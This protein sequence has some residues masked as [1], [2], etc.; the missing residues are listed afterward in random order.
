MTADSIL[1]T[2][3][4][5]A[6]REDV[7]LNAVEILTA[8]ETQIF[9]MLGKVEAIS[10]IHNYLTDTLRTP[11]VNAL[12]VEEAADY[13][14]SANTTP[15]RLTNLVE[16]CALN[17][18]VSRT[19]QQVAHYT[20]QNEL[21][22]QTQKALMDWANQAEFDLVRSAMASGVSGTA[23]QLMGI[24]VAISL[25]TNHTSQTSGTVWSA[26]ILDGLVMANWSNSNGDVATDIFM[27][28]VLRKNTDYFT[29]KSNVVVNAPGIST[30]VR[31]VSTYQT[32]FTTLNIHTHRYVQQSGD[33]TG[34]VLA[35]RPE[36]LKIAFLQNGGKPYIDTE[37]SRKGDYDN[38]AVVG[39]FTLEVH[40]QNSGF[41]ADGYLLA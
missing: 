25:S 40:N 37:L 31:T 9:N 11:T 16:I 1:R 10:T 22:R 5:S 34:R 30:I 15:T 12:A 21:A 14:A 36:K 4:D 41:Y 28:G 35:I 24:I 8:R 26:S 17:F 18:L 19:Q 38:R 7:V 20:G 39:K 3:G 2:Y 29:Q 23:P 32:A 27:G 13:T 33:A 6:I